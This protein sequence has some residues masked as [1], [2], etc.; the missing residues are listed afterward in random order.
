MLR[1]ELTRLDQ[2]RM[3]VIVALKYGCNIVQKVKTHSA[4]IDKDTMKA[5]NKAL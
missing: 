3:S 2:T 4:G 1:R 5:I